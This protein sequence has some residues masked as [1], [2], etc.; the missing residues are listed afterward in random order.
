[1]TGP[2]EEKR[3]AALAAI[4]E[5]EDGMLLGLGTGSTVAYALS[6]LA[7][8]VRTGLRVRGVATSVQTWRAAQALGIEML[9]F[10]TFGSVDLCIDGVDEIDPAFRAIKGAGGALLREKIVAEAAVRMIAIADSG[11]TVDQLGQAA[12]P[13]EVLPFGVRFVADRIGALGGTVETRQVAGGPYSTDQGNLVLDCR[14]PQP[15]QLEAL[16]EALG[17]IPGVMGH[18]LFLGEI[19]ALYVARGTQVSRY[20][21]SGS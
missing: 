18:G 19:D 5:V 21:R 17:A 1:M 2:D 7:E 4:E 6:A 14:F 12:V 16:A 8:R 3:L 20:E 13:V 10:A 15:L 9:D 11:K